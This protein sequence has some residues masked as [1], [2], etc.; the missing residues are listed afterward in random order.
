MPAAARVAVE[1]VVGCS[2]E[3]WQNL[4]GLSTDLKEIQRPLGIEK[5]ERTH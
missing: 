2:G 5:K 3:Q 1:S 4:G